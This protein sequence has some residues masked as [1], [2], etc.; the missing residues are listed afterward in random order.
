MESRLHYSPLPPANERVD[1]TIIGAPEE[2]YSRLLVDMSMLP[3]HAL[4]R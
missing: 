3:H 4:M 1:A 2:W